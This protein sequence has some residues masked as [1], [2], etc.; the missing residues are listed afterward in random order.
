MLYSRILFLSFLIFFSSLVSAQDNCSDVLTKAQ[1]TYKEGRINEIA[2]MLE[3]C[4]A[5]GLN[6][7]EKIEAYRLLTLTYLYFNEKEKA[8][9]AM[10]Q[11]LHNDPEYKLRHVDPTEFVNLYNSFRTTPIVLIG[12]KVG[13][14]YTDVDVHKNFSLDDSSVPR[15]EYSSNV[16]IQASVSAQFPISKKASLLAE[17]LYVANS[18]TY[19]DNLFNYASLE[20]PEKQTH[21]C[22][23]VLFNYNFGKSSKWVPYANVGASVSYLLKS[24]VTPIRV[25]VTDGNNQREI[26]EGEIDISSIR[27][28]INYN[29]VLGGGLKVKDILGRG[30]LLLDIRYSHGL[31]NVVKSKER[32]SN[33]VLMYS[34]MYVDNDFKLNSFQY[35]LG[36]S[37]P[38]YKP[39]LKKVKKEK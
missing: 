32:Y 18:Y 9:G 26:K 1:D 16:G 14:N 19:N 8:E 15:G 10:T 7:Q 11:L 21:L 27:K 24:K 20:F 28:S 22:V 12:A 35:S 2:E 3:P 30:Y 25:D 17:L 39:K 31:N 4:L 6:K 13:V 23:P 38:L 36:Y 33:Q 29:I 37:Y 5:N 34:Y